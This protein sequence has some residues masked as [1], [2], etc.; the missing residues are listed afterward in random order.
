MPA[1]QT[2]SPPPNILP[3]L[4]G[5]PVVQENRAFTE[6]ALNLIQQLWAAVFGGG[7]LTPGIVLLGF[8]DNINFNLAG[9]K[10]IN[11]NLPSGAIGWQAAKG[12]VFGTSGS[13]SVV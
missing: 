9:D 3:P 2:P 11:L 13:F 12:I 4:A 6:P 5:I 8:A 7:G 10:R 1:S